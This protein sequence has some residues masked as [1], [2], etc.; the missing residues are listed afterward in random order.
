MA[1]SPLIKFHSMER[2]RDGQRLFWHRASVDGLP[3]RGDVPLV[4]P[5]AEYEE[6]VVQVADAQCEFFDV[7]V[8]DERAAYLRVV[9]CI[10]HGWYQCLFIERFWNHT[11][12]HYVEWVEY[13][14]A[15]GQRIPYNPGR[16]VEANHGR[17]NGASHP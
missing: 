13:F 16:T 2:T 10:K 1:S 11:S 12:K 3:F 6:R 4:V 15:D 8:P 5:E 7:T 14:L 9:E 17:T